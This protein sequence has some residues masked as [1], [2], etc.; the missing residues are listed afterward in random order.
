MEGPNQSRNEL[1]IYFVFVCYI[2]LTQIYS[3]SRRS[4]KGVHYAIGVDSVTKPV[5]HEDGIPV[6]TLPPPTN[7]N[8]AADDSMDEG[9][10]FRDDDLN[11]D[12][13]YLPDTNEP[14]KLSQGDLD[15]LCRDLN[16][17]KR[18]SELLAS[19]LQQ[20]SLLE[21]GIL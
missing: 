3:F 14:H 13:L 15:D 1:Y 17:S 10:N 16:L 19:C 18:M 2:C 20:W 21:R 5:N 9:S 12:P 8:E 7:T 6:P 11:M 4:G